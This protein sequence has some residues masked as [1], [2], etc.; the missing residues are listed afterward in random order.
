MLAAAPARTV[1][2]CSPGHAHG[3]AVEPARDTV[4][5]AE[6]GCFSN[7]NQKHGLKRVFRVL[8]VTQ[9]AATDAKH[10]RAM[11]RQ[12]FLEGGLVAVRAKSREQLA[13]AEAGERSDAEEGA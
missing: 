12:D 9:P 1:G 6:R 10:H 4:S 2:P 8:W 5:I 7:K 13:L 11:A 3:H